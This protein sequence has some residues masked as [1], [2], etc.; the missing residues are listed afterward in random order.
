[1]SYK[2]HHRPHETNRTNKT[3]SHPAR[4]FSLLEILVAL[5]V[6]AILLSISVPGLGRMMSGWRLATAARQ[7]V[8]ELK[9]IRMQAVS[10][11]SDHRLRLA[12]PGSSYL[13]ERKNVSGTYVVDGPAT[14]LPRGVEV[15][16]CTAKGT[17]I[18]FRPLGQ[19]STFGTIRLR[20]EDG[21]ERSV[22]VDIAGRLRVQ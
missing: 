7:L 22:V 20:N 4:G 16:D 2:S 8:L 9:V 5:A 6:F 3:Y 19:A 1:M 10:E 14:E 12:V 18:T 13:R 11:N 15:V 17:A 21:L